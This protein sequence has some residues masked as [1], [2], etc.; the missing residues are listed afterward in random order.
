[1]LPVAD[2]CGW[3][4]A[5]A[6]G[7]P[8]STMLLERADQ[9]TILGAAFARIAGG[10]GGG[11]VLVPG[12]AGIG[13]TSL[14]RQFCA[15]IGQSARVLRSACDPLFTPRPLGPLVELAEDIRSG[16]VAELGG[17]VDA[18]DVAGVLLRE[19]KLVAPAVVVIEDMHWADE[20]TLDVIR[21]LARRLAAAPVLLVLS[22]RDDQLD[23]TQPLRVVL[24][25]LSEAGR[26]VARLQL[27]GLSTEAVATLAGR[28]DLDP[29]ELH[30]RTGGNPFFVTE[31]IGAGAGNTPL[32]VRDA[33]LA[34][35]A[36]LS[37]P[38]RNLLD[39][40]A[41][42][43]GEAES[44]LLAAVDPAAVDGL[45][46]CVGSGM[47]TASDGRVR[48]RHEIARLMIEQSLAP[49][50]RTALNGRVLSVLEKEE[51][52]GVSDPARLAH[53][54]EA[55][56]DGAAVLRYAPEAARM[57]AAVGAHREAARLYSVA[58][59]Y[60]D[61]LTGP[62]RA[63]LLEC[64]AEEGNVTAIGP[65]ATTAIREAL[66]IHRDR[67]DV[68]A[69]GRA[70]RLLGNCL[71]REGRLAESLAANLEAVA[72]L[73]QISP[74]AE[75]ALSYVSMAAIYGVG[76][77]A[78]AQ[79]WGIKAI[80]LGEELGCAKAVYGGLNIVGCIK[81]VNGDLAGVADL[82][83]SRELAEQRSDYLE[84]GRAHMH[85]CWMLAMSREW[86][87]AERS[88]HP[89]ITFCRDHG[90]ELWF[91]QL[92]CLQMECDLARGRWKRAAAEAD[93]LLAAG[94]RAQA[95]SRADALIV[96]G[97]LRVRR[98]QPGGWRLLDE[99]REHVSR[100]GYAHLLAPVASARA[101]AAWLEGRHA[102]V[103]EEAELADPRAPGLDP[104]A[105][106]DL[107]YWRWRAGSAEDPSG[108]REP[109]RMLASGDRLG[110]AR[111]WQD[112]GQPYQAALAWVGSGDAEALRGSLEMLRGLGARPA[113]A[114]VARELRELGDVD[115]P[116]PST[117]PNAT[118]PSGLTARELDVLRLLA[119][120]LR[121]SEIAA[122]LVLSSR[123]VDHH[124][125]A[126]MR[127]LGAPSRGGAIAAAVR[128]GLVDP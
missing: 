119:A 62:E 112:R 94:D 95:V 102:A 40:A 81:I 30:D 33:V 54:A 8:D 88:L 67:G 64:Y 121:N 20:A 107:R 42:V 105:V 52:D 39:V 49:G 122:Q 113:M 91:G 124:V 125:S 93:E 90:Q 92:R 21:L 2:R 48:F 82:E 29:A 89:A 5:Q 74:T 114:I 50:R 60:A 56:G 65:E 43:P 78:Q 86:Q 128:L 123:T 12:E 103:L 16:L 108:L 15:G 126:I 6:S 18:F 45:D 80:R 63:D 75:L 22:Y 51:D 68:L 32:S 87:V 71:G 98:G 69:E 34:R 77:N 1:V 57:A 120:G 17:G 13:K 26:V 116:R 47:L 28:I 106:H 55:A 97:T 109:Y 35:A 25:E 31:V 10:A 127:K 84:V 23:R 61:R 3:V 44:W 76:L 104:F 53:H 59:S 14:L 99:A 27:T 38:A 24:G 101:E 19:L 37:A 4:V 41:V 85:L 46:E 96:L 9:L 73:E 100:L 11:V 83:R 70:L 72:V 79:D 117:A 7:F 118:H 36:R 115:L 66:K 111:W 110:A 58:L